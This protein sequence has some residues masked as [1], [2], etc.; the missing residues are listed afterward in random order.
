VYVYVLH[1]FNQLLL[2]YEF[3]FEC[4]VLWF[5]IYFTFYLT[6]DQNY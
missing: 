2:N 5:N 3:K 4:I 6:G 1:F